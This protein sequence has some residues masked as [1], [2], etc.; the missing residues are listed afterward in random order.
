MAL[1]R[2]LVG[3]RKAGRAAAEH[4]DLLAGLLLGA[5]NCRLF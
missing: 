3:H 5:L 4:S 2:E 1:E